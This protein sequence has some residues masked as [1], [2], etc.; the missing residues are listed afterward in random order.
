MLRAYLE[1]RWFILR[2]L[3]SL[4]L[5]PRTV[6]LT[7]DDGP[8]AHADVTARL[9]AVLARHG[10]RAAFSLIG[11]QVDREPQLVRQ[12]YRAGHLLVNHSYA[13]HRLLLFHAGMLERE[14]D[15]C[16]A[17]I[18]DAL[19]LAD[20]RARCFRPPGGWMTRCVREVLQRRALTL[21]PLTRWLDDSRYGPHHA[22]QVLEATWQQIRRDEGG[23]FVFHERLPEPDCRR[24]EHLASPYHRANRSWVPDAVDQL[25][26][27][28]TRDG[29]TVGIDPWL[30][31]NAD[32]S[33]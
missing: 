2:P 33:G 5:P 19:G 23:M 15:R 4:R 24:P 1:Q 20:F 28:L 7:F 6:V 8:N 13:H 31:A 26:T 9:L 29:Y 14:I 3:P 27:R 11:D 12:V 32:R 16:D 25:I 18:A 21:C 10:V 22:H 30:Q 17:A